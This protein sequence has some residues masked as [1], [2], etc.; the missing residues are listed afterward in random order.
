MNID[1]QLYESAVM[2]GAGKWRQAWHITIPGIMPIIS[3]LLVLSIPGLLSA[4]FDQIFNLMNSM[5]L[6]VATVTEVYVL[7]V[8]L[9]QGQYEMGTA[10]GLVFGSLSLALVLIANKIS[11]TSGAS[12]IW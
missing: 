3:I 2:D 8:G 10:L 4:G 1:P 11:K 12:G 5:V 7:Q 6:G 9:I